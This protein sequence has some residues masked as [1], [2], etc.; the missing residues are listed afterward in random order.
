MQPILVVRETVPSA[1]WSV[2]AVCGVCE[3]PLGRNTLGLLFLVSPTPLSHPCILRDPLSRSERRKH[4]HTRVSVHSYSRGCGCSS[5]SVCACGEC[6]SGKMNKSTWL[7][8]SSR[9]SLLPLILTCMPTCALST[10]F[11]TTSSSQCEHTLVSTH[12]FS[13][14]RHTSSCGRL[15]THACSNSCS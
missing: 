14:W 13:S 4:T 8:F 2:C 7:L 5:F 1:R 10:L 12:T 9:L 3:L 6:M 11:S 15:P